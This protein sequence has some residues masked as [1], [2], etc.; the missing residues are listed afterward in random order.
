VITFTGLITSTVLI[1][2]KEVSLLN[3]P[4]RHH[5]RW[6]SKQSVD[7]SP[8]RQELVIPIVVIP[9]S[10]AERLTQYRKESDAQTT[11]EKIAEIKKMPL[12]DLEKMKIEF[13]TAKKG[14]PF[15][16]AF[17]DHSWTDWFVKTY[18]W[19]GKLTH[20]KYLTY[21]EKRLDEEVRAAHQKPKKS[22]GAIPN[23]KKKAAAY[24]N[25]TEQSWEM[26]SESEDDTA[27]FVMALNQKD[28]EERVGYMA[29]ENQ[30]LHQR[31]ASMEMAITELV[32]HVKG[33]TVKTEPQ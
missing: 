21:V 31:M 22:Q 1:T 9:M 19:S 12:K 10:V 17:E 29:Q 4:T 8:H 14:M 26:P 6:L 24:S 28:L 13:G 33:L 20:V 7:Q 2:I 32:N 11:G 27:Q 16:M 23:M 25:T 30:Q 18:E 5:R 3:I 15:P